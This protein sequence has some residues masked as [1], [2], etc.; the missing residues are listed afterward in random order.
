MSEKEDIITYIKRAF[1]L[2]EQKCYKQA[3]EMLYKAIAIEPDNTEILYQLGELYYLLG[4]Y[5]RAIQY[6]EQILK[7]EENNIPALIL[8][9][10]IYT[11]QDELYTAKEYAEKI[12]QLDKNEQNL[13]ALLDLYG[14]LSLYDEIEQYFELIEHSEKC[15]VTYAKICYAAHKIDEAEKFIKK[16]LEINPENEYLRILSGKI[17]FDKNEFDKAKDIFAS[18]DKNTENP[19]VLNY[20]GLF[21]L[22]AQNFIDAIKNFSKA[23]NINPENSAYSYNL[24]N[25]YY[26]NG[27]YEEAIEAYKKALFIDAD[28]PDYRYSLAYAYYMYE[29]YDKAKYEVNYILENKP[30]YSGANVLKGLISFKEKNYIEAERILKANLANNPDDEFTMS[31][32]SKIDYELGKTDLAKEYLSFL[33]QKN[34]DNLSY[35][36]DLSD[37][38]IKLKEYDSAIKLSEDIIRS[39]PNY[40]EGFLIGA[41]ASY[42]AGNFEE[43]KRYAQEALSVDINC[44]EGYYY[45]ALVRKEE[46]DFEEAIE[47]MRRAIIYDVNNAKYYAEMAEIYELSGD[48]KSAF[49]YV[50]EAENIDDSEEYKLLYRKYAALNRK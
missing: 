23:S 17:Y 19:E 4:N 24:G 39:N 5:S 50:K 37:V 47:C 26:L 2:R 29:E 45:L 28:N 3:I 10:K 30:N 46:K 40:I 27:W 43:T 32:L 33:I 15:I 36:S 49:E 34:P 18:F 25:A 22:D 41:R 8:T 42:A 20:R 31:A 38:Y 13:D 16:G 35:K 1:E 48:N 21:A 12:Y 6:P 44:A 11:K 7:I 9:M 14:K